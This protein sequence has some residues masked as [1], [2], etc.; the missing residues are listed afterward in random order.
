MLRQV[1]PI[2]VNPIRPSALRH[3]AEVRSAELA[4]NIAEAEDEAISRF[5]EAHDLSQAFAGLFGLPALWLMRSGEQYVV[6][7]AA[8][9]WR[10]PFE[11]VR[12]SLVAAGD[13]IAERLGNVDLERWGESI[14]A[15]RER[16]AADPAV[17]LAWSAGLSRTLAA[18][19][20]KDG[21]LIAPRDVHD[22]ANDNDEIRIAARMAGALPDEQIRQIIAIARGFS[23]H[24][25]DSLRVLSERAQKH[26][27]EGYPDAAPFIQGEA[28]ARFVREDQCGVQWHSP[29]EIFGLSKELGI[30]LRHF[31]SDPPTLEG[32]AVWGERH[33]PGVFLNEAS[34]RIHSREGTAVERRA[35]ARVTMAHELC[36][37]L[38]DGGHALSAVEVLKARMPVG[39]ERRA[40]SFAGE[41]LLPTD[42]ASRHWLDAGRPTDRIRL[43]QL[44][45]NLANTYRV[46]R[47]V[48]AW[49]VDH[50][51][52]HHGVDLRATLDSVAPY[53]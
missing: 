49:K 18:D 5:E 27:A 20:L 48:A 19:L 43:D 41:L 24:R 40:K 16:D 3:L 21:T 12:A 15:W 45:F 13:W 9:L 17:L 28:A 47:S 23:A 25:A 51:T 11:G 31:S 36:H 4:P 2:D 33:G 38:L 6:E 14:A 37:L 35:G 22:A 30:E 44:V 39:V 1:Y 46:T 10:L 7:A 8:R 42:A 26:I 34:S 52:Q 50:A 32:L 53:R 29:L